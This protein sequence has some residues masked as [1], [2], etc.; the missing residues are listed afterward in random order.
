MYCIILGSVYIASYH[1]LF[2]KQDIV[3]ATKPYSIN[4]NQ[5]WIECDLMANKQ[6]NPGEY[7]I[8]ER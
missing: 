8:L 4:L 2:S 6:I 3:N 7:I 5:K 1:I